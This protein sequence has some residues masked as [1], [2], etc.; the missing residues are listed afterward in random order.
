MK[1]LF[2]L[3]LI[4]VIFSALYALS[5]YVEIPYNINTKGVIMP[6]REWRLV[7]LPDGTILNTEKDNLANRITNYSVLEFRRGDLAE[8]VANEKVFSQ[9]T[10]SKGDT[11]GYIKSFE[12]EQRLLE[13]YSGLQEQRGLL[14]VYLSGEKEE[15]INAARERLL[16]AEQEYETQKKLMARMQSL[17]E[18]GVIAD[19]AW[20][21]AWND[22]QVKRQNMNIALSTLEIISTGA[23]PEEIELV[24]T[25]I[26]SYEKQIAQTRKRIDAFN[27][28]APFSGTILR[29][30]APEPDGE[31]IIRVAGTDRLIVSLPVDLYQL[32]YIE[33]GNPVN[34][35]INSGRRTFKAHVHNVDNTVHF[36]DMR[37]KVF[38]TAIV[39]EEPDRFLPNML[40]Q[41]EIVCQSVSVRDYLKRLFSVVFEN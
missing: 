25:N 7:R 41:A 18:T 2:R 15:E 23:K 38:V 14:R 33:N 24:R 32:A 5:I 36:I 28:K 34:L 31:S 40:V 10:V 39:E 17:H 4:L 37:Q 26:S 1:I 22:Y 3:V 11:V 13:L 9:R 16:L 8:F 19:E 35:K 6:V 12:E 21:L 20:E 29:Q 27:I 30:Q